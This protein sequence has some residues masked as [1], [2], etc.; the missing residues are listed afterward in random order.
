MH[1]EWII[2]QAKHIVYYKRNNLLTVIIIIIINEFK[3]MW[4]WNIYGWDSAGWLADQWLVDNLPK[5][6]AHSAWWLNHTS[7]RFHSLYVM[8]RGNEGVNIGI[9]VFYSNIIA[10][11]CM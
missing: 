7:W 9:V 4:M 2:S 5:F 8:D 10:Y 3:W 11:K 1:N 6:G